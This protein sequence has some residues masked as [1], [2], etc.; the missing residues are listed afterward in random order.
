MKE[1]ID[2]DKLLN[3]FIDG[4]LTP[5]ETTKVQ[6]LI[7]HDT[8]VAE[9]LGQLQKCKMLV[10]SL[11][12]AEAPIDMVDDIKGLLERRSLLGHLQEQIGLTEGAKQLF[13]RKVLTVAAMFSLIAVLGVVIYTIVVPAKVVDKPLVVENIQVPIPP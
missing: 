9:R 1:K 11:P 10:S 8:Q 6:R 7:A 5:R 12:V 4:E 13:I 3:G 2:I